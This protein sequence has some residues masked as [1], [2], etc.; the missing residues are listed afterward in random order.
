M[1]RSSVGREAG[2]CGKERREGEEGSRL[3][4]GK[5]E[6]A[7]PKSSEGESKTFSFLFP[8]SLFF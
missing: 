2:L 8:I 4:G 6:W 7:E 1:G 5:K 3:R